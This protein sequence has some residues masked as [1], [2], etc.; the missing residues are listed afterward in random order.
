APR[1]EAVRGVGGQPDLRRTDEQRHDPGDHAHHGEPVGAPWREAG[2]EDGDPSEACEE[3]DREEG[4][5]DEILL[6]AH[7]HPHDAD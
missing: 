4:A 6:I 3:Q 2:L 7:E 5:P 1:A